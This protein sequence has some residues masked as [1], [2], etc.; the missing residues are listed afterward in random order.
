M[1]ERPEV[2]A[3]GITILAAIPQGGGELDLLLDNV[4]GPITIHLTAH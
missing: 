2:E 4:K 3:D 1:L